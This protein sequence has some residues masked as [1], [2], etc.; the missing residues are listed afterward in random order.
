MAPEKATWIS[1]EIQQ[2][3]EAAGLP[4]PEGR[5]VTEH[6]YT[7]PEIRAIER[8]RARTRT[9]TTTTTT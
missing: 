5:R 2:A 9:T 4:L 6:G 1:T 8:H 3:L 7:T